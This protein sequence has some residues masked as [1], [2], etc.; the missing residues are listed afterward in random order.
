[1]KAYLWGRAS[2]CRSLLAHISHSNKPPHGLLSELRPYPPNASTEATLN[3]LLVLANSNHS[4]PHFDSS[5][6]KVSPSRR[7]QLCIDARSSGSRSLLWTK[8]VYRGLSVSM[9]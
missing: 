9:S 4:A 8:V 2:L 6:R 3:G 1:M 5:A 7:M